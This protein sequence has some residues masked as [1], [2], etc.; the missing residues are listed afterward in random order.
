MLDDIRLGDAGAAHGRMTARRDARPGQQQELSQFAASDEGVEAFAGIAIADLITGMHDRVLS[1]WNG[2]NFLFDA[3][4]KTLGCV[5]NAKSGTSGLTAEGNDAWKTFADKQIAGSATLD[6]ALYKR[7]YEEHEGSENHADA[8]GKHVRFDG[9]RQAAV[10]AGI[11]QVVLK[12]LAQVDDAQVH[13]KAAVERVAY[14]KARLALEDVFR[15]EPKLAAPPD[16][17]K[18]SSTDKTGRAVSGLVAGRKIRDETQKIKDDLRNGVLSAADA[19]TRLL[20]LQQKQQSLTTDRRSAKIELL[21]TAAQL[22]AALVQKQGELPALA[23]S[24]PAGLWTAET[25]KALVTPVRTAVEAWLAA[26]SK[27]AKTTAQ[28]SQAWTQFLAVVHSA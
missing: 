16:L 2:G 1:A 6:E 22:R 28:L 4:T 13:G 27:D 14:L 20:A 15:L 5:D 12:A 21:I 25:A 7:L 3:K 18:L 23:K 26:V 17:P 10:K 9:K 8:I 11:R 19:K 24:S